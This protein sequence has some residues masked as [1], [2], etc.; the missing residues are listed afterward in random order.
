MTKL[1]RRLREIAGNYG[2][3]TKRW[4]PASATELV[5]DPVALALDQRYRADGVPGPL[6]LLMGFAEALIAAEPSLRAPGR[7]ITRL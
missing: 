5:E 2:L 4:Q 6:S 3:P 1:A 7:A